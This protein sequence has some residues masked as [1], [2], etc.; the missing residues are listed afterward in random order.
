MLS[1]KFI[2]TA[3]TAFIT[4]SAAPGAEALRRQSE[5]DLPKGGWKL[6]RVQGI[7]GT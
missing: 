6:A 5:G 7:T 4:V 1:A 3:F 2:L